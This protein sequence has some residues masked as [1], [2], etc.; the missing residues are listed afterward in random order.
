M[1]SACFHPVY[2]RKLVA[3]LAAE[4]HDPETLLAA[5]K[6]SWDSLQSRESMLSFDQTRQIVLACQNA[7]GR[8]T[9]G[10]EQGRSIQL[11]DH[12]MLGWLMSVA[13]NLR[14]ALQALDRFSSLR[15]GVW[16]DL[17]VMDDKGAWI[18]VEPAFPLSDVKAFLLDHFA[19]VMARL[20]ATISNETLDQVRFEVP[21]APPAWRNAYHAVAGT[22]VFNAER[23]A[24]W[25]PNELLD[26][27]NPGASRLDFREAWQ[28]CEAKIEL[29]NQTKTLGGKLRYLLERTDV[30]W[31]D[32]ASIAARV[33]VS[34]STLFRYL[35]QEGTSFLAVKEEVRRRRAEWYLEYSMLPVGE[36]ANRLGYNSESNFSRAFR[37][38]TGMAPLEYRKGK[39]C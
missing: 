31:E 3:R 27:A 17:M 13:A 1:R 29:V 6:F 30:D 35:R 26:K 12:G 15:T 16:N 14:E 24:F 34:T 28:L 10:L 18:V 5:T 39:P 38:W 8:P 37:R 19:G 32:K 21:W 11:A 20:F 25:L 36:I 33:G 23:A 7:A 2:L 9:L 4:G 22:V